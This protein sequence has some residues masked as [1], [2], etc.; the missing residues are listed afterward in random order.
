MIYTD[1]TYMSYTYIL[2]IYILR[3]IP[4]WCWKYFFLLFEN[5]NAVL[6][7]LI[8]IANFDL[9]FSSLAVTWL[10]EVLQESLKS[11]FLKGWSREPTCFYSLNNKQSNSKYFLR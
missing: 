7:V 9:S 8:K 4:K 1:Q 6:V 10:M 2:K 5:R 11:A 3:Y